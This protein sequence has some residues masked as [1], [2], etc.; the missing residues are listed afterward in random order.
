[1]WG[2][3]VDYVELK[4]TKF[5]TAQFNG[6]RFVDVNLAA[7]IGAEEVEHFAPRGIGVDMLQV[8]TVGMASAG[9]ATHGTRRR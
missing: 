7:A 6:T 5:A 9:L 8:E 2:A 1:M 4:G 3:I